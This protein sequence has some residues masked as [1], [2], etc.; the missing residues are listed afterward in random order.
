MKFLVQALWNEMIS[1]SVLFM[2]DLHCIGLLLKVYFIKPFFK[3]ELCTVK[4]QLQIII[5]NVHNMFDRWIFNF[6]NCCSEFMPKCKYIVNWFIS[7]IFLIAIYDNMQIILWQS[8]NSKWFIVWTL[9]TCIWDH[10]C[11]K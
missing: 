7:T 9:T 1:L 2:I 5:I 4:R 6:L 3:F 10:I 8:C 11:V